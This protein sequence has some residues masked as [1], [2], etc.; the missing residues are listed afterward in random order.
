[1]VTTSRSCP[2]EPIG[3]FWT[4]LRALV[5]KDLQIERHTKQSIG[6]ML[7]FAIVAVVT[8]NFALEN[9]L[10]AVRE[11]AGGLLWVT[12]LLAGTLGLNRSFASELEKSAD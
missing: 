12:I 8:F 3:T 1:M 7:M 10:G 6:I 5:W 11:V 4:Q 9:N 2:D